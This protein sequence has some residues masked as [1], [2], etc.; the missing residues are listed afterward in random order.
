V[1]EGEGKR[2]RKICAKCPPFDGLR[3]VFEGLRKKI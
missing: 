1:L 2:M 3:R